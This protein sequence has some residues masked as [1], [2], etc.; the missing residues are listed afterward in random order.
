MRIRYTLNNIVVLLANIV[1]VFNIANKDFVVS[2]FAISVNRSVL[3]YSGMLM[4]NVF[5][6]SDQKHDNYSSYNTG[7]KIH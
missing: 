4:Y 5:K 1:I 3:F 7:Y 6:P 2:L